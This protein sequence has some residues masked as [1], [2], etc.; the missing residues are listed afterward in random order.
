MGIG[1][2]PATVNEWVDLTFVNRPVW[3][4]LHT[5]DPGTNGASNLADVDGRQ[6]VMFTRTSTGIVQ[7]TGDPARFVVDALASDSNITH[8]SLHSDAEGGTWV[9]NLV[10]LSPTAVVGGDEVTVGAGMEFRVTGWTA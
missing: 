2:A 4:Q 1:P 5:G 3:L 6:L 7:P 8:G 9:W 10:A